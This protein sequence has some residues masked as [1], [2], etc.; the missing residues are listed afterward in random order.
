MLI[1]MVLDWL[2]CG[3][4][5]HNLRPPPTT[6]ALGSLVMSSAPSRSAAG[7]PAPPPPS[8]VEREPVQWE[9]HVEPSKGRT[10]YTNEAGETV[11]AVPEGGVV[12][13]DLPFPDQVEPTA[14]LEVQSEEPPSEQRAPSIGGRGKSQAHWAIQKKQNPQDMTRRTLSLRALPKPRTNS[15]H[16]EWRECAVFPAEYKGQ[17][18][19]EQC[20]S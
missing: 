8:A 14:Q 18:E 16:R 3:S 10:F 6:P 15:N 4:D 12:V 7:E 17:H 19:S 13:G 1:S 2:Y 11:D 9:M 5:Q 20:T